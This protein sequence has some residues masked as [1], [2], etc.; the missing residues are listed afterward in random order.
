MLLVPWASIITMVRRVEP[1]LHFDGRSPF[2]RVT[3]T[4]ELVQRL[5][6]NCLVFLGLLDL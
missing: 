3:W 6:K 5:T 1:S 4:R 2:D